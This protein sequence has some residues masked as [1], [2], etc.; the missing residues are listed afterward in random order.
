[1]N[2]STFCAFAAPSCRKPRLLLMLTALAFPIGAVHGQTPAPSRP[3]EPAPAKAVS[4]QGTVESKRAADTQWQPVKLNDTFCPGDSIR[5]Q[6]KSRADIMLLNQSVLRLN[7][8]ST[9]TVAAPKDQ[10]TGVVDLL[11]G[12]TN[13]LSRGPRSLEVKHAVHRRRRPRHRVLPR[14]RGRP[15]AGHGVR[16]HGRGREQ[17][18]QPLADRRP[19]GRRRGRQGPGPAHG[20]A[21]ARCRAVDTVLPAGRRISGRTNSRRVPAGRAWSAAPTE[22]YGEGRPRRRA[23]ERRECPRRRPRPA[24]SYAIARSC[25]LAVGRVDDAH[26]P[27][28]SARCSSRRTT[29]M[30]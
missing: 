30:R 20:R 25:L 24:R 27:T 6:A 11:R 3:C 9:I 19:V 26:A 8:N 23:A 5:V 1:M 2:R 18:R 16:R 7:A 15:D 17:R 21:A 28:S 13:I 10:T 29:R 22:S 4:V 14:R 12:A